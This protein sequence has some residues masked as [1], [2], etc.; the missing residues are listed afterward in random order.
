MAIGR[1]L[2]GTY[3]LIA[4]FGEAQD[5]LVAANAAQDAGFTATLGPA[6][7]A[8]K[9]KIFSIPTIRWSIWVKD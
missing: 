4:E 9:Q 3:G 8:E 7:C 5:L 6:G 1:V 2:T